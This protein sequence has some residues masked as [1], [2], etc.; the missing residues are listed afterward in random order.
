MIRQRVRLIKA[1]FVLVVCGFLSA[2]ATMTPSEC[3]VADWGAVGLRDGLAGESRGMLD[4]RIKDCAEAGVQVGTV[5]YQQGR[6]R[7]LQTYCQLPNAARFGLDGAA[8]RGVC[9]LAIDAEFRR[10]HSLGK[11]VHDAREEVRNQERRRSAQENKVDKASNEEERRRAREVLREI[12]RDIR[13]AENRL[14]EADWA[15]DSLR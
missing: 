4:A 8:Y 7:G 11:A 9:P 3:Q 10:R 2:C 6:E 15:L 14:R 12:D 1:G 13:R 5:Q